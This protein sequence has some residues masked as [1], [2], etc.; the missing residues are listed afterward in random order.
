[1]TDK[2]AMKLAFEALVSINSEFVCNSAHHGK[3]DRHEFDEE[4]PI[5]MRYRTAIAVLEEQLENHKK[6]VGLTADEATALWEGTDDRDSWELIMR[7]Q[8]ALKEKSGG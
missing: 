7:V 4:C 6:W 8:K 2:E 3:K 5:D 1:M